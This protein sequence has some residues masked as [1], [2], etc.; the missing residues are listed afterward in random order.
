MSTVRGSDGH[1]WHITFIRDDTASRCY[2]VYLVA[3]HNGGARLGGVRY[4]DYIGWVWALQWGHGL[5]D[6]SHAYTTRSAA[7]AAMLDTLFP[8][9]EDRQP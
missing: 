8:P 3:R 4:E 5:A 6:H 7:T 2:S 9:R 1:R